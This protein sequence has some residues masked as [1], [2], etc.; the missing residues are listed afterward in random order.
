MIYLYS[1]KTYPGLEKLTSS[2]GAFRLYR[3]DGESFWSKNRKNRIHIPSGSVVI[4]WGENLPEMEGIK[5]LNGSEKHYNEVET[6]Q[7][8]KTFGVSVI[9]NCHTKNL[10]VNYIPRAF[11]KS[12]SIE[13]VSCPDYFSSKLD[14]SD[15]YVIHSFDGKSIRAGIKAPVYNM[16]GHPWIKTRA[17]GWKT[18]FTWKSTPLL[19]GLAHKAVKSL[20]LTFASV[21]IG[22]VTTSGSFVIININRAPDLYDTNTII[23]YTKT[24]LRWIKGEN[25]EVPNAI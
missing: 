2:L 3:F 5:V 11:G 18:D 9:Q 13:E 17:M 24:I 25:I 21:T 7:L 4:P 19:R 1:T 10:S 15:E 20:G 22:A 23:A 8:L 6:T 14:F 16:G 12:L